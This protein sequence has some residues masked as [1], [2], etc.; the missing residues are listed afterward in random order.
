[1]MPTDD[2]YIYQNA[3]TPHSETSTLVE[4]RASLTSVVLVLAHNG[5]KGSHSVVSS[6]ALIQ[7]YTSL[8]A[9]LHE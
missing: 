6:E 9:G 5:N 3:T 2:I 1:M 7:A 4:G 8:L